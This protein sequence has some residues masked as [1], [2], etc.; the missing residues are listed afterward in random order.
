MRNMFDERKIAMDSIQALLQREK[1]LF[2][3]IDKLEKKQ[4][5]LRQRIQRVEDRKNYLLKEYCS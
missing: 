5:I 1:K 4:K 2:A 3:K